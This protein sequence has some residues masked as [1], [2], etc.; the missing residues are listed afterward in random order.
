M[1]IS[2]LGYPGLMNGFYLQNACLQTVLKSKL[3]DQFPPNQICNKHIIYAVV[4]L[5]RVRDFLN[6]ENKSPRQLKIPKN[7]LIFE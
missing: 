4:D 1:A 6:F 3:V 2:V 7:A 5:A